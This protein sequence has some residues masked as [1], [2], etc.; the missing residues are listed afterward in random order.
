MSKQRVIAICLDAFDAATA[1]KMMAEGKLQAFKRFADQSA[2]FDLEHGPNNTARYTGLTMEHYSSGMKPETANKYSV[3]SFDSQ[4]YETIQSH[5]TLKPF[6]QD[7][8]TKTVVFDQPYFDMEGYTN[9]EGVVGWSG[10]DTGVNTYCYPEGLIEE[11]NSKFPIPATHAELNQMVYMSAEKCSKMADRLIESTRDRT[12]V[13]EWMFG[14]RFTDWDCAVMCYGESHDAIEIFL[15]G[16]QDDHHVAHLPSAEHARRGLEGVYEEISNGI[17]HLSERF[18]DAKIVVFT[19]HGMGKSDTDLMDMILLP[20]FMYR[21]NYGK[22]MFRARDDWKNMSPA[23]KEGEVWESSIID[24]LTHSAD[25]QIRSLMPRATRKANEVLNKF[26]GSKEEET[27]DHLPRSKP[28]ASRLAGMKWMP[29]AHYAPYWPR[30]KAFA[31]PAYF[32]API[33]VNLKGREAKGIVEL[34]DYKALLDD[35]EREIRACRDIK[36]GDP[37]V[38]YLTRPGEDDPMNLDETQGDIMI[39][40][41]GSPIGFRH[42]K[43]GDIGPAP[44]RRMGGHS[45]GYGAMWLKAENVPA[46]DYGLRSSFDVAPTV[47]DLLGVVRPNYM[48]GESVLSTLKQ[49]EPAE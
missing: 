46:G 1:R 37:V 23:L 38:K 45:G 28:G 19:M 11:L 20:E 18:P 13:A 7:L 2:R 6:F 26:M 16:I 4:N 14:E 25:E 47:V 30:M 48:D 10:H 8:G 31:I 49:M 27:D 17:E 33:R 29:A 24:Q 12:A 15:H 9:I 35:I 42:P 39:I 44:C 21:Y 40:W 5:A 43:F 41:E 22:E 36:T 34:A 32:A 3:V